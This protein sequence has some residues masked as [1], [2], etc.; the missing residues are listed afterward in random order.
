VCVHDIGQDIKVGKSISLSFIRVLFNWFGYNIVGHRK[1]EEARTVRISRQAGTKNG[2]SSMGR[3]KSD[4]N[5][6]A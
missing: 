4:S 3:G 2:K 1:R 5:N 6:E